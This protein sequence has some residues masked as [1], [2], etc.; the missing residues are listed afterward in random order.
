[1][2]EKCPSDYSRFHHDRRKLI[3][4]YEVFLLTGKE[5]TE[6]QNRRNEKHPREN[7]CSFILSWDREILKRRIFDRCQEMLLN[8]WIE[9]TKGLVSAGLLKTPTA[10]QAIGYSIIAEYL[11]G[12]IPFHDLA[13][14]ISTSTW[15]FARRQIT[16]F[17]H[18]H[19]EARRISLP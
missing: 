6:L 9:E 14:R 18:Q 13:E 17:N 2:M 19:P 11:C 3:R 7:V 16:W 1:M 5:I 15:Q 10:R 12:R 8:G 4:A